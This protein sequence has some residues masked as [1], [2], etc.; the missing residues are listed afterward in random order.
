LRDKE[1]LA[2]WQFSLRIMIDPHMPHGGA[3]S[4]FSIA[5]NG[6]PLPRHHERWGGRVASQQSTN[7]IS[8]PSDPTVGALDRVVSAVY[9]LR[10]SL[11]EVLNL[12][13]EVRDSIRVIFRHHRSI[14]RPYLNLG[15][16]DGYFQL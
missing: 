14:G 15:R 9:R 12:G 6:E 8:I 1:G 13:G 16:I 3:S 5:A 11:R 2:R 4:W 7:T 10:F